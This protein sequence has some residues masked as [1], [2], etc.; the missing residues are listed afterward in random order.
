MATVR[1]ILQAACRKIGVLAS[2]EALE[3]AQAQDALAVLNDM[4]AEWNTRQLMVY[5]ID[6]QV[7]SLAIGQQTYTLGAGGN[8]NVPRPFKIDMAGV[9]VPGTAGGLPVEIPIQLLTDEEYRAVSVK[10]LASGWPVQMYVQGNMPLNVLWMWP[11]P[12][13]NCQ[14]V[15]YTWN[16]TTAFTNLSDEVVFPD[17]YQ[18]AIVYNLAVELAT[19]YERE[20]SATVQRMAAVS[21]KAIEDANNEPI[22]SRCDASLVGNNAST[23][24]RATYGYLVDE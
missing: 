19:E 22:Y 14:I 4:L 21:V 1:D 24:A 5:T 6:R 9:I 11:T 8:F 12:L 15:L 23:L 10:T 18:K 17:G 20:A 16:R 2:G 7:F 3:A 13:Q